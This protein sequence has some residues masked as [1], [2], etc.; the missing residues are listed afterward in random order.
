MPNTLLTGKRL[1]H[2]RMKVWVLVLLNYELYTL[3]F[4]DEF[5]EVKH[6]RRRTYR[7]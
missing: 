2:F 7:G 5:N 1:Q 4:Y 6:E 3:T